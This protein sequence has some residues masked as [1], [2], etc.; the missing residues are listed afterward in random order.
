MRGPKNPEEAR[1]AARA[2]CLKC[3]TTARLTIRHARRFIQTTTQCRNC[4][5]WIETTHHEADDSQ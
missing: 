2:R 1:I 4:G 5:T 3:G